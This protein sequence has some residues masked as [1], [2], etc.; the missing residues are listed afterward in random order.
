MLSTCPARL[1]APDLSV[2][3]SSTF[4][5]FIL[6]ANTFF[7]FLFQ[8]FLKLLLLLNVPS[9]IFSTNP[10][11][12][13]LLP[14]VPPSTVRKMYNFHSHRRGL[15]VHCRWTLSSS[16]LTEFHLHCLAFGK[17]VSFIP[18]RY[19]IHVIFSSPVE[20][21]RRLIDAFSWGWCLHFLSRILFILIIYFKI[22]ILNFLICY[23]SGFWCVFIIYFLIHFPHIFF[24][25]QIILGIIFCF[26]FYSDFFIMSFF[27]WF[28]NIFF[29]TVY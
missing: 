14:H 24:L 28:S 1:N 9:M 4:S 26:L 20:I 18:I 12:L 6:L 29:F 25:L 15:M 5:F 27:F 19:Q 3:V 10:Q 7:F 17:H 21:F 13:H 23:N 22:L 2:A 16:F 11:E 8:F